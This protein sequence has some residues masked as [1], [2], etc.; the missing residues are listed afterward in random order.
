MVANRVVLLGILAMLGFAQGVSWPP[1]F[2]IAAEMTYPISEGTSGGF[3][4]LTNNLGGV[5]FIYLMPFLPIAVM[6]K[7]LVCRICC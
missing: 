4:G 6:N 1:L 5:V 7:I 3:T 2:E